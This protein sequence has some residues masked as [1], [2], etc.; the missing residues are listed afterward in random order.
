MLRNSLTLNLW[1]FWWQM[2]HC[3]WFINILILKLFIWSAAF[4][5]PR[6]VGSRSLCG[7]FETTSS[8]LS[9]AWFVFYI[10]PIG[11]LY[12]IIPI[13]VFVYR[14]IFA[15][16]WLIRVH[17]TCKT[18]NHKHTPQYTV[19]VCRNYMR[20]KYKNYG[21]K[22]IKKPIEKSHTLQQIWVTCKA[23]TN[24]V[25]T[26]SPTSVLGLGLEVLI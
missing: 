18:T 8:I 13:N 20:G 12:K 2:E 25:K 6:N 22:K 11:I 15:R 10:V 16:C 3:P 1:L 26:N 7:D 24:H 19:Y 17:I 4:S 9:C 23:L 5:L 14:P 21:K